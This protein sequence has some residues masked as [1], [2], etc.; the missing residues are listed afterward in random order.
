MKLK[1]GVI[2]DRDSGG[3]VIDDGRYKKCKPVEIGRAHV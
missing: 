2:G 1:S 3:G